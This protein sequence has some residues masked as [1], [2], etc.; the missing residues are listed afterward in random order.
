MKNDISYKND[1][2]FKYCMA[3]DDEK[4]IFIRHSILEF[5][6][7]FHIEK[8]TVLNPEL[9]PDS[10]VEKKVILDILLKDEKG[11]FFNIEMQISGY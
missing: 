9:L 7:G 2:F 6:L 4:S 3:G 8:T 5:I 1:V 10:V 11:Q